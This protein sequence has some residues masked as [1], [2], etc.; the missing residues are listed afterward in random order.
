[1]AQQFSN[2]AR[3][4]L[5]EPITAASTQL[6][7]ES[8]SLALFPV[9]NGVDWFYL[10]LQ[11]DAGIEIVKATNSS[12]TVA[13][14]V[15]Q[16]KFTVER[17]QQGAQA[18]A[19]AA[20]TTVGLRVTAADMSKA[21]NNQGPPGANAF[22]VV[23]SNLTPTIDKFVDQVAVGDM[24]LQIYLQ[25]GGNLAIN[26]VQVSSIDSGV[27]TLKTLGTNSFSGLVGP[28]GVGAFAVYGAPVNDQFAVNAFS[29]NV[30][31]GDIGVRM[32]F[33]D[34]GELVIQGAS[35][36]AIAPTYIA[37]GNY[38]AA[39]A[40][41]LKGPAGEAP[42]DIPGNV[43]SAAYVLTL[44]D[45]GRSIDTMAGV[46]VPTLGKV[47]FPVNSTV[48]VTNIGSAGITISASPGVTLRLAGT[49]TTGNRTVGPY[50]VA[51]LRQVAAG[52]WFVAGAGVS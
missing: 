36:T 23:G 10:T 46:T 9:P 39:Y 12:T 6:H 27:V 19:F 13:G 52:V 24:G 22:F 51:T 21:V 34:T 38:S 41:N 7:V 20:G 4:R 2:A 1:M 37:L 15:S 40:F 33:N 44:D 48:M 50:G 18:R 3:T 47:A 30:A 43:Q 5:A 11:D 8:G 45:R 31:V 25:S 42:V 49:T 14:G 28:A 32:Y 29:P 26:R 17:G 16:E 35:V